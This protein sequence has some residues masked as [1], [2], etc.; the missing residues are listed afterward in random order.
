MHQ[1]LT[2]QEAI[3]RAALELR[4]ARDAER[5]MVRRRAVHEDSVRAAEALNRRMREGKVD[6][7]ACW[8]RPVV[9]V[10]MTTSRASE[11]QLDDQAIR[12]RLGELGVEVESLQ[13][14][15]NG[16]PGACCDGDDPEAACFTAV[17][18]FPCLCAMLPWVVYRCLHRSVTV[19]MILPLPPSP[20]P[21][22]APARLIVV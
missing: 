6:V 3:V 12:R 19:T 2:S 17:C 15:Q 11:G 22:E 8:A 1:L 10:T 14:R 16:T 7:Y 9:A 21:P 18:C 5:E 4:K 13:H 20:P